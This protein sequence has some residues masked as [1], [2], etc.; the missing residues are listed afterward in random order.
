MQ[1]GGRPVE[2]TRSP[3]R[4]A[5]RSSARPGR[6]S[7]RGTGRRTPYAGSPGRRR[8][9]TSCRGAST[10]CRSRSGGPRRCGPRTPIRPRCPEPRSHRGPA[11][12]SERPNATQSPHQILLAFLVPNLEARVVPSGQG[13]TRT[14]VPVRRVGARSPSLTRSIPRAAPLQRRTAEP[15][16]LACRGYVGA[17]P[18]DVD[19]GDRTD[20]PLDLRTR[21]LPWRRHPSSATSS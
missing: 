16:N 12:S 17:R 14:P 3:A 11:T 4:S 20:G 1:R 19:A 2:E 15:S 18:H 5:C 6:T 8:P 7:T 21:L 9:G 10:R 13:G